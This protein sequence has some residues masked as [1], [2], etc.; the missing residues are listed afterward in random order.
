MAKLKCDICGKKFALFEEQKEIFTGHN[1]SVC[2]G[3]WGDLIEM[4]KYRADGDID[5]CKKLIQKLISKASDNEVI[6]SLAE[7]LQKELVEIYRNNARKKEEEEQKLSISVEQMMKKEEFLLTTGYNFEGYKITK[8]LNIVN[9]EIVLGTGF[10][11]ELSASVNDVLGT[12]SLVMSGKLSKAKRIVQDQL[13]ELSLKKGA[14]ALIG[15]DF[16]IST[17]HNNLIVVSG[18][19]TAVIIEREED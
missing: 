7:Y 9:S 11:S 15:I 12:S 1:Y 10:L 2:N 4:G 6:A 18:N 14:N 19:G 5:A 3:C 17:F 13:V 8:Y 16:D